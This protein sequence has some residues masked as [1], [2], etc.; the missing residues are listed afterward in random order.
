[1]QVGRQGQIG[2]LDPGANEYLHWYTC[3]GCPHCDELTQSHSQGRHRP[4]EALPREAPPRL[5]VTE[6]VPFKYLFPQLQTCRSVMW[7][8]GAGPLCPDL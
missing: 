8:G 6:K 3:L 4:R 2:L 5:R 1:M 7:E